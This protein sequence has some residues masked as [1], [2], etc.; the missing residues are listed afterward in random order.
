MRLLVKLT[1]VFAMA[2]VATSGTAMA[3]QEF[4]QLITPDVIFGSGNADG[5]WTTERV[6]GLEIGL[7]AKL[8]FDLACTPQNTFN[9]N[10]DGTYS[11][12]AGVAPD[13]LGGAADCASPET[14]VWAFE[15]SVNT[16][17]D[18]STGLTV[19]AYTYELGMD[20]DAS[21]GTSFCTFDNITPSGTV[22][23]FDHAFGDNSTANGGGTSA[24]DAATYATLLANENVAQ[25][26]WRYDFFDAAGGGPC[27]A[28][29]PNLDATYDIY[30]RVIDGTGT[31]V[32]RS[33]IQMDIGLGGP[34]QLPASSNYALIALLGLLVLFL[35]RRT[36]RQALTS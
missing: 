5:A 25:N 34:A 8:R 3:L 2:I 23:F 18:A 29:D 22:P 28:F 33:T 9:S 20:F 21:Q 13:G 17:Y 10:G 12:A 19:G 16:D 24:V 7:R 6:N 35:T 15:W 4:D 14:P 11:Y 32:A 36:L 27:P 31:E 26:S 30:L 1:V